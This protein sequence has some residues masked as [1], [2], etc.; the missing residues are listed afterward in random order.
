MQQLEEGV[1]RVGAGLAED[2]RPRVAFHPCAVTVDALAVALHVELLQV[3]RQAAQALVIGYDRMSLGAEEVHVP[4]AQQGQGHRQVRLERRL[5][6]VAIHGMSAVEHLLEAFHAHAERDREPHGRPKRVAPPDPIPECEHVARVDAEVA[7]PCRLAGD[8]HEVT[9]DGVRAQPLLQ[10]G[11]GR[12]RIAERLLGGER[13]GD[14][15]EQGRLGLEIRE[16]HGEVAA[17]HVGD[18]THRQRRLPARF[19]GIDGHCRAEIGAADADVDDGADGVSFGAAP[20]AAAHGFAE[21]AHLR[22]RLAHRRHDVLPVHAHRCVTAIAQRRVQNRA[23]FGHVDGLAGKHA[24]CPLPYAGGLGQR[25]QARHRLG[26]DAVLGVV[27]QDV[28]DAD[29]EALEPLRVFG[30]QRAQGPLAQLRAMRR[31]S[32]PCGGVGYGR[33][34]TVPA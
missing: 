3:G 4:H 21:A 33:Q 9:R 34:T 18:E 17:V 31:Q 27:E 28:V 13:L 26:H 25:V 16:R 29:R 8:G 23:P 6:K 12:V 14:D 20:C 7:G 10:P 5:E 19:Q 22:K 32:P 2:D 11:A 24:P 30:E 1:L 15:D